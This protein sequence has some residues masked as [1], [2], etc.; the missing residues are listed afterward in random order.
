M[1][2][3][4][5]SKVH[6]L[7]SY[8]LRRSA[9]FNPYSRMTTQGID[10]AQIWKEILCTSRRHCFSDY[11]VSSVPS[12]DLPS[13]KSSD[14]SRSDIPISGNNGT[15]NARLQQTSR[16]T[17]IGP[18]PGAVDTHESDSKELDIPKLFSSDEMIE[19]RHY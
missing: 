13:D 19:V 16:A 14:E 4:G 2:P 6:H 5:F 12:G 17:F 15:W 8:D 9:K 10:F 7:P 1:P 18:T 3:V 11:K